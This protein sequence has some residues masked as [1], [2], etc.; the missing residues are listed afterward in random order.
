M[1]KF[2]FPGGIHPLHDVGGGKGLTG[3][4]PV[5][6]LPAAKT[7]T[8]P[9]A[10]FAGAP[11]KPLVKKGDRV[12]LGQPLGEP[13]G[14]ISVPV[15]A[16]V[17]GKVTAVEERLHSN[18]RTSLSVVVENDFL[19][20]AYEGCSP[21][22]DWRSMSP[23]EIR[24]AVR[25]A[26]IVGMGGAA[27]PTH[28]KL[29][30]PPGKK[31]DTVLLNGTECEGYLTCDQKLMEDSPEDVVEGLRIIMKTVGASVGMIG[32]EDNKPG[33][34]A[35]LRRAAEGDVSLS[36]GV[37]VTKYPQG[38]EKH[39]IYSLTRRTVPSGKLP[40]EVGCAVLNVGTA[41][42]IARTLKTGIPPK[43]RIVT[44]SGNAVK[45]PS[46]VL[47]RF[48]TPFEE[49]IQACGGLDPKV[50]KIVSGGPLTGF[51]LPHTQVPVMFGTS[52]IICMTEDELPGE[53][54]NCIRCC[55]CIQGCPMN[56]RPMA[57]ADAMER[58]DL[59]AL[60]TLR[61][62]DCEEC[63]SCSYTC[64]SNRQLLQYVRLAKAAANKR[65]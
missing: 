57:I 64:P 50:A 58:K 43:E 21:Y 63:G 10:S 3:D 47:A 41:A 36:V 25:K 15:N 9:L 23:D 6:L 51:A 35:A 39:L 30:P 17:S 1:K 34:I 44:V 52:G 49:C 26:G 7:L 38:A 11:A 16:S 13:G 48:G 8:Y 22:P 45:D 19:D 65:K 37:M 12:L 60:T 29:L 40:S 46:N 24:E 28:I 18:G 42:A 32:V 14:T 55:K 4:K 59:D 33:A 5:K 27:F 62:R 56:L 2:T 54:M 20:E 53:P 31:I 61:V